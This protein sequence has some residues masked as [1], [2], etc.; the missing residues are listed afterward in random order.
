MKMER[1][2][3][4]LAFMSSLK[5]DCSIAAVVAGMIAVVV[6]Y[7][8][9]LLIVFQAAKLANLSDDMVSSWIWAISLS[10]GLTG[11][12]LSSWFK[13]P[14]ITAWSTPGAV[15][16]VASWSVYPYTDALGAF[17]LSGLIA[18]LLGVTGVFSSVIKRIP[19]PIIAAMLA[20]ILLRFGV[21]VFTSLRQLPI[22]ALPMILCYLGFKRWYPR[23]AVAVTLVVGIAIALKL[24]LLHFENMSIAVVSPIFMEPTFSVA[25]FIGLGVPL[26]IVTM[27]AQN[28]TGI[29][30]MKADGYDAPVSSIVTV[31]GIASMLFAP[32]GA[33]GINV[34]AITAAIC[35]GKEAHAN[36]DKRY[37]AGIACGLFYMLASVFGAT[38]AA[39]FAAFPK[40]LI[41]TIAGLALFGSISSSLSTAMSDESQKESALITFLITISGISILGVGAAFWGLIAGII[42]SSILTGKVASLGLKKTVTS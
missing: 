2:F 13:M 19:Q 26:C 38:I 35:T 3:N 41:A 27:T 17:V 12:L 31:T 20:G 21:E 36:P 8:G 9:P 18:T 6:S 30:L 10:T 16:L 25:A 4:L 1:N 7:A 24:D 11:V 28:A 22:L 34:A 23:Y 42:T 40:E 15:L 29:G 39:A 33:H 5:Q 14:I 37:I 32:F